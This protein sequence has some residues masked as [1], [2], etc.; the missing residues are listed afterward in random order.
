MI[1]LA[2][3]QQG[4]HHIIRDIICQ[5]AHRQWAGKV[6]HIHVFVMP[7]P[8]Q[9][10]VHLTQDGAILTIDPVQLLVSGRARSLGS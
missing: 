10:L 8:H 5:V 9:G 3:T 7:I 6:P 4:I 2:D 1:I